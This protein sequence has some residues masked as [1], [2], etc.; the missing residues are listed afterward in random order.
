MDA[1]LQMAA[2]DSIQLEYFITG[3]ELNKKWSKALGDDGSK[4][5]LTRVAT[6]KDPE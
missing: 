6:S 4:G 3:A 5:L 2:A 1:D